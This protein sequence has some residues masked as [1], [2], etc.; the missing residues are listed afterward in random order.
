MKLGVGTSSIAPIHSAA[1]L[2]RS[3]NPKAKVLISTTKTAATQS[4]FFMILS[5][6]V[7]TDNLLLKQKTKSKGL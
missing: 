2:P 4:P 7:T 6:L 3:Y 5:A 1:F